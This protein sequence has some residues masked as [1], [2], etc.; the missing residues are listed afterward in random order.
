MLVALTAEALAVLKWAIT[1]FVVMMA[2]VADPLISRRLNS[3]EGRAVDWI[4]RTFLNGLETARETSIG[5]GATSFVAFRIYAAIAFGFA[6][7]TADWLIN[8]YIYLPAGLAPEVASVLALSTVLLPCY[9]VG[10]YERT[11]RDQGSSLLQRLGADLLTDLH[12]PQVHAGPI[13]TSLLSATGRVAV[14]VICRSVGTFFFSWMLSV[15]FGRWA[16]LAVIIM[17]ITIGTYVVR[18]IR[19]YGRNRVIPGFTPT[20]RPLSVDERKPD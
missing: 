13:V 1:F 19:W 6:V 16:L 7:A 20:S 3:R 8:W 2:S 14:S 9:W 12:L 11:R 4:E 17:T 5:R 10:G 15:E 18:M